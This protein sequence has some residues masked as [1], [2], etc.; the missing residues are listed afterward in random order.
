MFIAVHITS[1]T[2]V[3]CDEHLFTAW[4]ANNELAIVTPDQDQEN[5][6]EDGAVVMLNSRSRTDMAGWAFPTT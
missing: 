2:Y 3:Q 4:N 1:H 6:E 5:L